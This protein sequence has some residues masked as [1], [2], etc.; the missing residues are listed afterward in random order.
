[1]SN[2]PTCLDTLKKALVRCGDAQRFVKAYFQEVEQI[3]YDMLEQHFSYLDNGKLILDKLALVLPSFPSQEHDRLKITL[4]RDLE[5]MTKFF[6]ISTCESP[7]TVS[8]LQYLGQLAVLRYF[9]AQT[10]DALQSQVAAPEKGPQQCFNDTCQGE[11]RN[12]NEFYRCLTKL[13]LGLR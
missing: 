2:T 6:T 13:F 4:L 10:G 7:G 5:V 9:T 12:I 11:H 8:H 3:W 1:M